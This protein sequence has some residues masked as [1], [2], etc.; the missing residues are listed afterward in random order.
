MGYRRLRLDT[1]PALTAAQA[2]Y[3]S[4]GFVA[5]ERYGSCPVPD[6]LYFERL[7]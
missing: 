3:L 7:L 4:L 1:L 5:I 6:A 2:L